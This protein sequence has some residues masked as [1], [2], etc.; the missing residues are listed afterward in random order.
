MIQHFTPELVWLPEFQTHPNGAR[1]LR[2]LVVAALDPETFVAPYAAM[3]DA[4]PRKS[5]GGGVTIPAAQMSFDFIP[6]DRACATLFPGSDSPRRLPSLRRSRSASRTE[7]GPGPISSRRTSRTALAPD[8][9]LEVPAD[10]ACG[11]VIRLRQM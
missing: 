6:P 3:F 7:S 5:P 8:G 9:A 2:R 11:V 1:A 4:V 10:Q